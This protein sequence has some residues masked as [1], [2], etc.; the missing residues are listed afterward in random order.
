MQAAHSL[1]V[2]AETP[3]GACRM[4]AALPGSEPLR[5]GLWANG[6]AAWGGCSA[7][8]TP[9]S[10]APADKENLPPG[11]PA[12]DVVDVHYRHAVTATATW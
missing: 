10:G 2:P 3:S 5:C 12:L 7:A 4:A 8:G 1:Q 9:A 6:S 11:V